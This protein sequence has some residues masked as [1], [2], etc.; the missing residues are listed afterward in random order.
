MRACCCGYV[1]IARNKSLLSQIP[2]VFRSPFD[3]STNASY[4]GVLLTGHEQ[5]GAITLGEP[6][7]TGGSSP[8]TELP[9]SEPSEFVRSVLREKPS[10]VTLNINFFDAPTVI[11]HADRQWLQD[12][13]GVAEQAVKAARDDGKSWVTGEPLLHQALA[14]VAEID[15]RSDEQLKQLQ[16]VRVLFDLLWQQAKNGEYVFLTKEATELLLRPRLA[17]THVRIAT[18]K[19]DLREQALCLENWAAVQ[20]ELVKSHTSG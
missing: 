10:E 12:L 19:N 7:P 16:I 6:A 14:R 1:I 2:D 9:P 20:G 18:L 13:I 8:A 11:G 15:G 4:F 17:E 5:P 3:D